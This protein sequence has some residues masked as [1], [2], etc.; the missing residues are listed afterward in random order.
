M[1]PHTLS[2]RTWNRTSPLLQIKLWHLGVLV[3]LVAIAIVDIQDHGRKEPALILLASVG[4]A[5]FALICWLC[6]HARRRFES[7][8]GA[9]QV[10]AVYSAAMGGL[11]LTATVAYLFI[12]YFYLVGKLH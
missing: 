12:E 8:L 5:A 4:Y 1:S 2:F 7:R 9:V 11:F 6:W 3:A 10:V